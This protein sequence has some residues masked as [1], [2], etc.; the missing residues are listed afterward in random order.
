DAESDGDD[1]A[2]G[3]WEREQ[4]GVAIDER[5]KLIDHQRLIEKPCILMSVARLPPRN[6]KHFK[7]EINSDDLSLE[8]RTGWRIL[9]AIQRFSELRCQV[10]RSTSDVHDAIHRLQPGKLHRL[11]PPCLVHPQAVQV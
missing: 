10:T 7:R 9:K 11:P 6:W 2:A 8:N 5:S 4:L 3:I 1:V